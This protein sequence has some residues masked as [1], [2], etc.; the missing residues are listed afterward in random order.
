[1]SDLHIAGSDLRFE[2]TVLRD[3][4]APGALDP[5]ASVTLHYTAPGGTSGTWTGTIDDDEAGTVHHDVAAVDNDTAG[6]WKVWAEAVFTAG[7]TL[8]TGA[9]TVRIWPEGTVSPS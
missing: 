3:G 7:G 2:L 5:L 9:V 4:A 8:I 6:F 1:M